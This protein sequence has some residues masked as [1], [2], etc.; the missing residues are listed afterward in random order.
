MRQIKIFIKIFKIEIMNF[1]PKMEI[2]QYCLM[3]KKC[4]IQIQRSKLVKFDSFHGNHIFAVLYSS[5]LVKQ[6]DRYS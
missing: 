6:H 1:D 4:R 3:F 2:L 5:A